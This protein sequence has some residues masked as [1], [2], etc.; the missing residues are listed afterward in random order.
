VLASAEQAQGCPISIHLS[1]VEDAYYETMK[2]AP[3]FLL[4]LALALMAVVTTPVVAMEQAECEI[5]EDG[6]CV[7][8]T[9][10]EA[11]VEAEEEPIKPEEAVE[12]D[13]TCPDRDHIVRCTGAHLDTN[14]NGKLDRDELDEGE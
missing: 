6:T 10:A 12:I 1:P 7:G 3:R 11:E 9:T 14:R 5:G 13:E 2:T 8:A 4:F